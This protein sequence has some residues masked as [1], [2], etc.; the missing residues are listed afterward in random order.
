MSKAYR[1]EREAM[2]P[3]STEQLF[4]VIVRLGNGWGTVQTAL[5][6]PDAEELLAR[7]LENEAHKQRE[8]IS[9]KGGVRR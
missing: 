3:G 1:M 5:P 6:K 7:L 8:R 4:R 9:Y 2:P